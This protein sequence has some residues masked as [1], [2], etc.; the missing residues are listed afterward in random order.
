MKSGV[1]NPAVKLP[2]GREKKTSEKMAEKI[3]ISE[4]NIVMQRKKTITHVPILGM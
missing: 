3:G 2:Q 4:K 1:R